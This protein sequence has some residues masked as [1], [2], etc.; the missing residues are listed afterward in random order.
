MGNPEQ[1][2]RPL[3]LKRLLR[4]MGASLVTLYLRIRRGAGLATIQR[5]GDRMGRWHYYLAISTRRK[6]KRQIARLF[7]TRP[8][9]PHI[10]ALLQQ[11]W[12]INDRAIL[13]VVAKAY[14]VISADELVDS[15]AVTG[16]QPLIETI[17]SGD[18]AVLLGMH[19]G[20]AL[21]LLFK[22]ARLGLPISVVANQPR[23][24]VDGFFED[25]F[26]GSTVEVIRARPES[27]AFLK[28]NKAVKRGRA[29]YIPIDQ[30]HKRGGIPTRFLG[31][32]VLMPGGAPALAR[33]HGVPIFPVLLE[34][35]EPRWHY[36][37]GE[38]V[39]LRDGQ[40]PHQ[41]IADLVAII[42]GQIRL[43]PHFWS[44]HQRRWMRYPFE[45][46]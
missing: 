7:E 24:M 4:R 22:L 16:M 39:Q 27:R 37:I 26:S 36:R 6:L 25:F 21:A 44:W 30:M 10:A 8:D 45:T 34:A 3:W 14:G 17:E 35:V 28:L 11:A 33:R 19:S 29:V 46:E 42:E 15:V 12:R 20:N 9:D 40:E 23:R 18:G 41:D 1:S 5:D 2:W 43:H 38:R 13:E 31:K 32:Q